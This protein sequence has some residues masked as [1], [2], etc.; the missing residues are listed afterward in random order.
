MAIQKGTAQSNSVTDSTTIEVMLSRQQL[1]A[2]ANSPRIDA[3]QHHTSRIVI[4]AVIAAV[5]AVSGG[6]AHLAA[7]QRPVHPAVVQAPT[8]QPPRAPVEPP[9]PAAEPVLFKN[10]FDRSEVFELPPGTTQDEARDAVAK[11]LLDRAQGRGP[12]VLKLKIRQVHNSPKS[13]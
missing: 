12:E 11:L 2:L 8:P 5:L 9:A 10:P 7:M 3:T 4:G 1:S 13:R 6:V